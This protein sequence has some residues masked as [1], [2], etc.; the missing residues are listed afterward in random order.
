MTARGAPIRP[1]A[2]TCISTAS[3]LIWP[4]VIVLRLEHRYDRPPERL[5]GAI[6]DPDELA[7]WFP[8]GPALEVT[9]SDPPRLLTGSWHGDM[10]R[11]ELRPDGDGV[12]LTFTHAL[13]NA[14]RR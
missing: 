13:G 14:T 1:R 2:G 8:P 7:Q 11:F 5:W 10:L 6:T 3:R 9:A 12:V 4:A